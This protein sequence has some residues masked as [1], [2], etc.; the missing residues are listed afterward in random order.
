MENKMTLTQLADK[1]NS[2]KHYHG[3]TYMYD[4]LFEPIKNSVKNIL[5]IGIQ[6]GYSLNMWRDYFPSA[7]VHG[8]DIVPVEIKDER[9]KTYFGSQSDISFLNSLCN[10]S[11]DIIIDDGSHIHSDQAITL[12]VL[13]KSLVKGGFYIIEDI[14]A[15]DNWGLWCA[16]TLCSFVGKVSPSPNGEQILIL[17][18]N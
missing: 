5:E 8:V 6:Y 15:G 9:I 3:Y 11:Y 18:K 7:M 16:P 13:E 2:D 10:T 4:V 12:Q 17:R 1:Y 14:P